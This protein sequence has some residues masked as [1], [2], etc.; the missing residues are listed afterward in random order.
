[1]K[2][3]MRE[4]SVAA[5]VTKLK[6]SMRG[7]SVAGRVTKLHFE[8]LE[9]LEMRIPKSIIFSTWVQKQFDNENDAYEKVVN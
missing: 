4:I 6:M 3:S 9:T 1:M 8:A 5:R 2:M 7:I